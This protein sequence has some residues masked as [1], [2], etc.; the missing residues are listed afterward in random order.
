M[1]RV[2]KGSAVVQG[3]TASEGL[4][5]VQAG[6]CEIDVAFTNASDVLWVDA[7]FIES[8]TTNQPIVPTN[9]VSSVL[10]FSA[11]DGI[12][13]LD[14]DGNGG[15]SFVAVVPD[16]PKDRFVR[17]TVRNDYLNKVYDVWVDGAPARA[18]LRFKNN[19]V[20]KLSGAR[21]RSVQ[22]NYMDD[23]SVSV[24]GL[25]A[26]SDGDGLVDLDEAKFYGS[27]PLL[28]DSDGDGA[29]DG[30]ELMAQTDPGDPTSVFAV[31]I[32]VNPQGGKLLRIPTVTGLEYTLQRRAAF[33]GG[34]WQDIQGASGVPGDGQEKVFLE[35]SDGDNFF[36]RGVI[37]NR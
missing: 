1:W 22:S 20:D 4:Q 19:S 5:A 3:G 18:G 34:A 30:S 27:Y 35:T 29:S 31:K 21:R 24:W 16:Y 13:A 32:D 23:F 36:Y 15:G 2:D 14:G 6:E 28:G 8:G 12:L 7:F 37:I 10:F 17:I 11:T 26:D 33:G 25:D 9:I